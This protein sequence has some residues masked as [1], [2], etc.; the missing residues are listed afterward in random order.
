MT[1]RELLWLLVGLGVGTLARVVWLY[2]RLI[3]F[4]WPYQWRRRD[5]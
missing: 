5:P 4:G 3:V 2:L 1:T